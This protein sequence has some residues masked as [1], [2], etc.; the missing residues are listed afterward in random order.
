M[1]LLLILTFY[2]NFL[3][4]RS[5]IEINYNLGNKTVSMYVYSYKRFCMSVKQKSGTASV[6]TDSQW[7]KK[8]LV[9][10]MLI[11]CSW[12]SITAPVSLL[13]NIFD[14]RSVLH[15]QASLAA[16][17]HIY[18]FHEVMNGYKKSKNH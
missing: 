9:F 11:R 13:A 8:G 12:L 2:Y 3:I 16:V 14:T 15:G 5:Y 7:S 1:N 17:N 6:N 10:H 18:V 4:Y